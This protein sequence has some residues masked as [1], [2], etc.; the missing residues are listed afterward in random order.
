MCTQRLRLH[1]V[2]LFFFALFLTLPPLLHAQTL[3]SVIQMVH[4]L[5]NSEI[6]SKKLTIQGRF[7]TP[8]YPESVMILLDGID[9]T[10]IADVNSEGF[11]CDLIDILPAGEHSIYI[12]GQSGDELFEY[13]SFFISRHHASYEELYSNNLLSVN[14]G[15]ALTRSPPPD[16]GN[17]DSDYSQNIA[18]LG[19]ASSVPYSKI[20]AYLTNETIFKENGFNVT[21]SGDLRY[22]NQNEEI[23][24]P[25]QIGLDLLTLNLKAD[26]LK[27]TTGIFSEF[28]DIQINQ[29]VNTLESVARRGGQ[30][31]LQHKDIFINTFSILG[32]ETFS[33]RDGVGITFDTDENIVGVSG[34]VGVVDNKIVIKALYIS[35]SDQQNSY[36]SWAQGISYDQDTQYDPY[37]NALPQDTGVSRGDVAGAILSTNLFNDKFFTEFEYDE[38]DYDT[39]DS[40]EYSSDRDKA[41]RLLFGGAYDIYSY[42]LVYEHFGPFYNVPGARGL[43]KDYEGVTATGYMEH[44]IHALDVSLA[45][46]HDNVDSDPYY[47]R[48]NSLYGTLG[49]K[50]YGF[51]SFIL[52]FDYA[53]GI[54]RSSDEPE[55]DIERRL[56]TDILGLNMGYIQGSFSVDLY[57]QYSNQNDRTLDDYDTSITTVTLSPAYSLETF[58]VFSSFSLNQSKDHN[59]DVRTDTYTITLDLLGSLFVNQVTYELGGTYDQTKSTDDLF[60]TSGINGY[61]RLAYH[62]PQTY[63]NRLNSSISLEA[64]YGNRE[65]QFSE[66]DNDT[67]SVVLSFSASL[68]Y[69]L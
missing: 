50:Y 35:G 62:L 65:E 28:G 54:D 29:S 4:P 51:D 55:G 42:D 69:S 24:E 26:Y 30:I 61:C 13:E 15:A 67:H 2:C 9:L 16:I 27:N 66:L 48:I 18:P 56:D 32:K 60:D 1:S 39:D 7:L 52:G 44:E 40:D 58:S 10:G 46:Y 53:K 47:S 5:N 34:G 45:G 21:F 49:Y 20:D 33:Y 68:P 25:E 22:L 12:A 6:I 3:D 63:W 11:S 59:T 8:I 17:L 31:T 64:N 36:N 41:Y 14:Y 23:R 38:S 37:Y 19:N 57:G 43:R